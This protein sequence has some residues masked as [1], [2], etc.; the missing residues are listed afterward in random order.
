MIANVVFDMG[1]VLVLDDVP[2][3]VGGYIEDPAAQELLISELVFGPEWVEWDRGTMDV[4]T[5]ADHVNRRLPE[6]LQELPLRM[7]QDWHMTTEPIAGMAELIRSLKASGYGIYLL[8]NTATSYYD[9]RDA[10]PAIEL[11]DGEFVSAD[12]QLLK[13]HR[14]IYEAFTRKFELDPATCFFV[15]D[16]EANVDGARTAGWDGVV[17]H[18]DVRALAQALRIRGLV[19]DEGGATTPKGS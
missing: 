5:V 14:E 12:H 4:A 15:D 8:S 18:G 2:A 1:N 10:L 3:F 17:F 9:Y 6:H 7:L 16:K 19:F 11:F 13:P